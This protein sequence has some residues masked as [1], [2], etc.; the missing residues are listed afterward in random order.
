MSYCLFYSMR[1]VQQHIIKK[2]DPRYK[3]LHDLCYKSKNLYNASLY[4]VRQYYFEN[5]KYL[6]YVQLDSIF[7]NESNPDYRSLPTQTAQ[8]TMR[9]V[10]HNFK[11]FFKHLNCQANTEYQTI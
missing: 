1:L 5:K 8:Q 2:N 4:T 6:P 11:S 3:E 9:L 10:D 7:K